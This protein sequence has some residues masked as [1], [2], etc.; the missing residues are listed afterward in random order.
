MYAASSEMVASLG[1]W[2]VA[3]PST[4]I[5]KKAQLSPNLRAC[6]TT[7][8][9]H[10]ALTIEFDSDHLVLNIFEAPSTIK[11]LTDLIHSYSKCLLI[12]TPILKQTFAA[13]EILLGKG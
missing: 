3:L 10:T 12:F 11:P 8:F 5:S 6:S 9:T 2:W 4:D 7:T 13:E 1:T